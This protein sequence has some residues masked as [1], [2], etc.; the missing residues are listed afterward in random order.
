M[1]SGKTVVGAM[2]AERARAE[3]VDLDRMVEKAAGMSIPEIF[4]RGG[5]P[6]FRRI[7]KKTLALALRSDTV[8][9]LGGGTVLDDGSWALL[10]AEAITV[11]LDVPFASLWRRVGHLSGR[12]LLQDRSREEIEAMFEGRRARYE[13]AMHRVDADRDPFAVAEEVAGLWS[14]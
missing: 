12:P 9:A 14:A 10:K 2:V 8:V 1:G 5:E 6:V 13:Q 4:A 11:Y 3:F 7:E